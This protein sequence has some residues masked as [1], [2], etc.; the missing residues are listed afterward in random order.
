M[1]LEIK[2]IGSTNKRTGRGGF[3]PDAIVVHIMEG[4][5]A[6]T[7]AWFNNPVSKVSA[8]YGIGRL[9]ELHQYVLDADT[10]FHA[11]R[12]NNPTWKLIRDGVNPNLYTIGLEHEAR[13]ETPW[14]EKMYRA[15]AALI[16]ELS[17]RWSI[18][19]D[20]DH[21]VGHREIY[22]IKTCPGQAID[23]ERLVELATK[24]LMSLDGVNF[25]VGKGRVNARVDLN[26]RRQAPTTAARVVRTVEAGTALP[27][28]GWTSNGETV[29]GNAHWY[30]DRDGNYFWAG[31]TERQT[32]G[33]SR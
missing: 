17:L 13:A 29:S 12:R 14:T 31:G 30:R 3:R 10:A 25:V 4:S 26:V 21:I 27:F 33:L 16:A 6:G 23:L 18:P 2:W 15:S 8:H 7:D 5:L 32:P 22:S 19:I 1:A 11:G 9:G 20:R 28:V 24:S